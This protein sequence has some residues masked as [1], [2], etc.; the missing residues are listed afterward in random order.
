M[1][2][3]T[4]EVQAICDGATYILDV[5]VVETGER[6]SVEGIPGKSEETVLQSFDSPIGHHAL[7]GW[8]WQHQR[9]ATASATTVK[10][11]ESVDQYDVLALAAADGIDTDGWDG[12]EDFERYAASI[13]CQLVWSYE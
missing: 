11:S 3:R 2:M 13:G 9:N 1:P 8:Y 5:S 7:L 12:I 10:M 4:F 6:F